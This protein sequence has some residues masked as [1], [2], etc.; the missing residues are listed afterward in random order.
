MEYNANEKKIVLDRELNSLDKFVVDFCSLLEE[1]VIV[2]GYVS[3]LFGRSRGTEDV[4]LLIPR[5]KE[6][7]FFKIFEKIEKDG[8]ECLN[9]SKKG[10][11]CL[12]TSK[13]G[14]AFEMLKEHA[15]RFSRKS[16][17]APNMKFKMVKN[18]I[19]NYSLKNKIL[20]EIDNKKIYISPLEMQIAYK[21]DLGSY[22]D[23]E[24]AKHIYTLFE[25]KLDKKELDRLV[26]KFGKEEEFEEI[27]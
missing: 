11:E 10:F 7:E 20:V 6:E 4:D 19:E 18:D 25:E 9:T 8:F 1:Y 26:E 23:L 12:N 2:S 14:E 3:I 21:L 13:K 17:P 22:K 5:K 27:K 15:I 16:K 24:D